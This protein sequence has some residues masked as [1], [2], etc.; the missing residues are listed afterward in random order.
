MEQIGTPVRNDAAMAA[1]IL[2][3][4]LLL[5]GT[6]LILI[7][8]W[9]SAAERRQEPMFEDLLGFVAT[10]AG[11]AIV[12]WWIAAFLLAIATAVLRQSGNDRS[13]TATARLSPPFMRRLAVAILGLNLVGI[14]LANAAQAAV[15]PVWS[16]A[17]G[18]TPASSAAAQWAPSTGPSAYPPGLPSLEPGPS[19][20]EPNWRPRAPATDLGFLGSRPQR[21]MEPPASPSQGTVVVSRGDSLWSIAAQQLGPAASDVDI[22]LQWPKWYAANRQV[23]G[24]NPGV[25]IPGQILQPPPLG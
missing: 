15:E 22:A 17:D 20:I 12:G 8:Q 21:A 1:T 3:L 14:P 10:A 25:L 23:I 11:L 13:A 4:G 16:P 7:D 6:G 5:A 24:D 19:D 9:H 18:S 2:I